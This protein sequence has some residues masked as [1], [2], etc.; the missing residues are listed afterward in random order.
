M[1]IAIIGAGIGGLVTAA[2]LQ[3]DGHAVTILERRPQPGAIGAGIALFGN[4]FAALDSVGLGELIE[5]LATNTSPQ[6]RGGQRAPDGRWL[7]TLPR[8]AVSSVRIL[9]RIDLHAALADSLEPGTLHAGCEAILAENGSPTITVA[10]TVE[11]DAADPVAGSTATFDL[12]VAADGIQSGARAAMGLDT[13]LRYAGYTA[14][15]GV[16]SVPVDVHGEAAETWGSGRRFGIAPLPD[17]RVYWFATD[18][19]P[20]GSVFDDDKGAVLSRFGSWHDPIRALVEATE[21]RA[22]N[23]HDIFDLAAPLASYV[24][25]RVVLLGDAAHAM[26][27]DLGQGAGQ[28]IEDAAT[29]ALLLRGKR[30]PIDVD[31]ALRRYDRVRRG[32]SQTIARRSRRVGSI[33]QSSS[34][35]GVKIRDALLR[36]APNSLAG[37]AAGRMQ[38]WRPP[39][40]P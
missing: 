40:L 35:R 39:R 8:Q 18:S 27:P 28:A 3:R 9:H 14:W 7:I 10:S 30:T 38:K 11:G 24:C 34:R 2:A 31:S 26:T 37:A 29:L 1:R 20:Q 33:A 22:I 5:P 23:R 4:S 25:G 21:A 12:V 36:A 13:G 15:R 19:V 17:G 16:T 6:F 32:R